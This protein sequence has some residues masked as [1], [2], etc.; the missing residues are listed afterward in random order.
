MVAADEKDLLSRP[1]QLLSAFCLVDG[2][3]KKYKLPVWAVL[4]HQEVAYGKVFLNDYTDLADTEYPYWYPKPS[5][6]FDPGHTVMAW[7][8]EFL[9]RRR[10]M[11]T[12]HPASRR[13]PPSSLT[14]TPSP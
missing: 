9:L 12:I 14:S 3:L 4:S 2:L 7:C 6:R 11:W 8:R 13:K 5:F 10:N 1:V